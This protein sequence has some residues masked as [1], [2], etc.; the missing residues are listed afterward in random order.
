M[1]CRMRLGIAVL[2]TRMARAPSI[3]GAQTPVLQS[4]LRLGDVIRIAGERKSEIQ[5]RERA[6]QAVF[7][8]SLIARV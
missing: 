3:V 2:L 7:L 5:A 4:P 6:A 8:S 1:T